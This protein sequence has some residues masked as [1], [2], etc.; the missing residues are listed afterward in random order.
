M[1]APA[2]S[3]AVGT[4]QFTGQ[5]AEVCPPGRDTGDKGMMPATGGVPD[6]L[7]PGQEKM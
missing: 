7:S 1:S 2:K 3:P 5:H 6:Y 4:I